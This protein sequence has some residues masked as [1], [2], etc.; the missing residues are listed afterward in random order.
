[1]RS[2]RLSLLPGR[3]LRRPLKVAISVPT[4]PNTATAHANSSTCSSALGGWQTRRHYVTCYTPVLL[5]PLSSGRASHYRPFSS[6]D[7]AALA[8]VLSSKPRHVARHIRQSMLHSRRR[9]AQFRNAV[10]YLM[11]SLQSKLQRKEVSPADATA[12]MESLM[13]E[14]VELRQGD[15]AHLLFRASIRFRKYG[16]TLG[17]PFVR[18]LFESYKR[19]N[20]KELMRGMA[21]ELKANEEMRV[22]AVLAYQFS[23]QHEESVALWAQIPPDKLTT[24][25]YCALLESLGMTGRYDDVVQVTQGAVDDVIARRR[26]EVDLN[27]VVS[28][29]VI[30]SRGST[31]ALRTMIHLARDKEFTLSDAAVGAVVRSRLQSAAVTSI[32][33]VYRVESEVCAELNRTTL[34]MVGESAVIAKCSEML[35]RTHDSGDEVMLG[36]VMHLRRVVEDAAANDTL[37]DLDPLF[38]VSLLRGL[39]VLGRFDDMRKCFDALD[40]AGAVKDQKLYDEML[41]WYAHSYNLKEVIAL[42]EEMTR[43][44]I[45]HTSKTYLNVFR[46]LGRYYPRLVEKYL[47]EMRARGMQVDGAMYPTLVRVFNALNDTATVEHLYR[48]AKQKAATGATQNMSAMLVIQM[49]RCFPKD[50]RRC[51]AVVRDAEQYG[52]LANE[53]VQAEVL[54]LYA[55]NERPDAMRAFLARLPR[56]NAN[57]YRVLLRNAAQHHNRAQFNSVLAEMEANLVPL[58]E[59]LFS[60]IVTSLAFF[61]DTAGVEAYVHKAVTSN[62]IHTS[63]FFADAASAFAR[64]GKVNEVDQCWSDLLES[65]MAV[66]MPVYNRFLDVYMSLNNMAKVQDILDTMMKLVPP[67]PVTATTVVDMLGKMGRLTEMEAILDEMSKSTNAVPTLVTY[68]QAMNAYAKCGDVT[69]MESIREKLKHEGFQENAVTYNILFEGYGR[70]K[71]FEHLQELVHERKERQIAME[72]FG[73]VVLLNTYA[74]GRM[75]DEAEALVQEMVSSSTVILTSRLLCT[76]AS[77]FSRVGNV[78]EMEKYIALLLAHPECCQRDVEAV[79][80]IYARLRDTVKLQALLD[81]ATLPKSAHVY[82]TCVS[83][84]ARAGEHAKVAVLLTEMEKQGMA[85][86]RS[87]SVVLSSLLLKAG[88]LELAQMVLKWNDLS[89]AEVGVDVTR[90]AAAVAAADERSGNTGVLA[91]SREDDEPD[92]AEFLLNDMQHHITGADEM[93]SDDEDMVLKG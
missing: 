84:F 87:T 14:C 54:N 46:V 89:P 16:L 43:K 82:N 19:E 28:C 30:A 55:L 1:M 66:T 57:V 22:L 60:V 59:R 9:I 25:D 21:E 70:A 39:G 18:Y 17:F 51:E 49:L 27:T 83:A 35:A 73:Y 64:L 68:H 23:G 86:S 34:G 44:E 7:E 26:S 78:V 71:R 13:K 32:A 52:L 24:G 69:K 2:R 75:S 15:M 53:A 65:K 91:G 37:D 11:I 90:G 63:M 45:Y 41:R 88:K 67:N 29:A 92:D 56:K 40:S 76:V 48:E 72:E 42:K 80:R 5:R 12:I 79:Y 38:V 6:D 77:T 85:L 81:N 36:K 50:F 33:A 93:E 58:N 62:E 8:S 61:H 74:R 47:A 10:T 20:A 4:A 3:L 31:S